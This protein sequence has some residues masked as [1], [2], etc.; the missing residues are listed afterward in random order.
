M[1]CCNH[2]ICASDISRSASVVLSK[3]EVAKYSACKASRASADGKAKCTV[4]GINAKAAVCGHLPPLAETVFCSANLMHCLRGAVLAGLQ[5][6][7]LEHEKI[8][9][10]PPSGEAWESASALGNGG[11]GVLVAAVDGFRS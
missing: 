6:A 8:T 4:V 3:T 9:K 7:P 5:K 1:I 11:E 10:D 2:S